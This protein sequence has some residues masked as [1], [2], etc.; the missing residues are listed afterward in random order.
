MN[1]IFKILIDCILSV[2][3]ITIIVSSC[4][5]KTTF[6]G[7]KIPPYQVDVHPHSEEEDSYDPIYLIEEDE[8]G[9][10]AV[11]EADRIMITWTIPTMNADSTALEDLNGFQLYRSRW[12]DSLQAPHFEEDS[13]LVTL[14]PQKD[15]YLDIDVKKGIRYYYNVV[16]FDNSENIN[17]SVPSDT[18]DYQLLDKPLLIKPIDEAYF[19]VDTS[20]TFCWNEIP[21]GENVFYYYFVKVFDYDHRIIWK[22]DPFF[23][24]DSL[25]T[26]YKQDGIVKESY[27]ENALPSGTYFWKVE[28]YTTHQE[29]TGSES[30]MRKFFIY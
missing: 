14:L 29:N 25:E 10:D 2:I 5:E 22:S 30:E 1:K 26:N 9:I 17:Q 28:A 15:H 24:N 19:V 23:A 18:I 12:N 16:A 21:T 4:T 6:E 8:V 27:A 11:P 20:I 13:L 3:I 7:D